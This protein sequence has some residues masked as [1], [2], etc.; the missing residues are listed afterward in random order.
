MRSIIEFWKLED[1]ANLE[2]NIIFEL[3]EVVS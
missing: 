3:V 1:I 2:S